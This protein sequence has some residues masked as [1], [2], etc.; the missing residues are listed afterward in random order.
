M[1]GG[2]TDVTE[3]QGAGKPQEQSWLWQGAALGAPT[4]RKVLLSLP[5]DEGTPE[6]KPDTVPIPSTRGFVWMTP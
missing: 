1:A 2:E 4:P 5:G 3:N 6:G